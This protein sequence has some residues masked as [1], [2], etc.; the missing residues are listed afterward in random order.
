[1][2]TLEE[3]PKAIHNAEIKLIDLGVEYRKAQESMEC[4]AIKIELGVTTDKALK[5][6]DARRI[7]LFDLKQTSRP[8]QDAKEEFENIRIARELQIAQVA[9]LKNEFSVAK[10]IYK[11]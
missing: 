9:R 8:Y 7:R 2:L 5:N 10:L 1:M 6:A 11:V 4:E 3:Y